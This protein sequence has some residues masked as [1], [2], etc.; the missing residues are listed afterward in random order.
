MP[1]TLSVIKAGVGG[2][3]GHSGMHPDVHQAAREALAQAVQSGLLV[4][5]Q[6]HACGDDLFLVMSH[7]HGEDVEGVHR[8][9][10]DAFGAC[11]EVAR[12]LHLYG[13]GQDL[14]TDG[15]AGSV[16]G[17]GLGVAELVLTERPSEPV[18]VFMG[19]KTATGAFNLPLFKMFADPFNTPGL[20]IG[21]A[22][23]QGFAFEVHDL[24]HQRKVMFTTPEETY[25][26]LAFIGAPSQY[27]VKRIVSR[28]TGE[29]A[30][31]A[32]TDRLSHLAGRYAGNDDPAAIVRCH[33]AF[34]G[35]GEALEPFTT[36]HLV[37]GGLRGSHRGPWMPV[38][39][40]AAAAARFDGP[41]VVALG[42]QLADGRLVG[43]RDC[44]A[45]PAFDHARRE[46]GEVTDYLRRHGPFEPH[47][48]P[49]DEM[50]YTTMPA[51]AARMASRWSDL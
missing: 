51:V 40:E 5:A 45:D 6:A 20:V 13:A 2:F 10:W 41:R 47:R 36:P 25:D 32:S 22:L 9:A 19:D 38:G 37:E 15:F 8:M 16:H 18:L 4:D 30:A 50:E 23:H 31:V 24:K 43:T 26:L 42:F 21:E 14:L 35:V 48:L 7:E 1:Q 44:F 29:V 3:V 12:G 34:P 28:A 11:A 17:T 33:G 49:L 39:L 46:A 27:A